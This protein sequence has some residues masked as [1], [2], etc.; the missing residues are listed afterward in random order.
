MYNEVGTMF[1]HGLII[2]VMN[3]CLVCLCRVELQVNHYTVKGSITV[4]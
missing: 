1:C 2:V 4:L 3:V